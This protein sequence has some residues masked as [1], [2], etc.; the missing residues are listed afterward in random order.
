[1]LRLVCSLLR[2]ACA[3]V[4]R[5]ITC[6]LGLMGACM[7]GAALRLADSLN[8]VSAARAA[9]ATYGGGGAS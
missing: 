8:G 1:M 7:L 9:A 6:M 5:S 4:M 2:V 3:H